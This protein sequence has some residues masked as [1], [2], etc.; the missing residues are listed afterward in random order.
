MANQNCPG[1]CILGSAPRLADPFFC[2]SRGAAR[3]SLLCPVAAA[4]NAL[5]QVGPGSRPLGSVV[6]VLARLGERW[7]TCPTSLG[8]SRVLGSSNIEHLLACVASTVPNGVQAGAPLRKWPKVDIWLGL[9]ESIVVTGSEGQPWFCFFGTEIPDASSLAPK[10]NQ[11]AGPNFGWPPIGVKT[12]SR[13]L[14]GFEAAKTYSPHCPLLSP[15]CLEP[16]GLSLVGFPPV[17]LVTYTFLHLLSWVQKPADQR[18]LQISA[19][20]PL[21]LMWVD[22]NP[23]ANDVH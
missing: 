9:Q 8:W 23:H 22:L 12:K 16:V 11:H 1:P 2:W 3:R 14:F 6:E 21:W 5:P 10:L 13:Q 17:K 18:V 7:I 19:V 15:S 4:A 20:L